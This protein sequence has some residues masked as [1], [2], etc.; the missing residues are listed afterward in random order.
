MINLPLTTDKFQVVTDSTA[1]AV[2]IDV[3]CAYID[4]DTTSVTGG[5]TPGQQNTAVVTSTTG[6]TTTDT[7]AAPAAN[8]CRNIKFLS[9]RNT[10]TISANITPQMNRNGTLST[11]T[12][13]TLLTDEMYALNGDG[14]WFHYDTN[15]GIY[16]AGQTFA[17]PSDM[18]TAT[19]TALVVSPGNQKYHPAHPK[20]F[21][22]CG[23]AADIQQSYGVSSLTDT[24]TGIVTVNLSTNFAATTYCALVSVEATATTWA[25]ANARECHVRNA[26][27]AVG[28]VAFD[29]IDNTTTTNLVKDPT[30]WHIVMFG[31]Q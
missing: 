8:T 23:V 17:Q 11:Y 7:V 14:T 26:S 29:C 19:S 4:K 20:V 3:T 1:A 16:G 31:G 2:T 5:M 24:G 10:S 30:T 21:V 12:K 22:S 18:V 6:S 27:R 25:I 9:H 13:V 28:S 15:G